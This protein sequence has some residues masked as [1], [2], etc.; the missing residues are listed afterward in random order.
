MQTRNSGIILTLPVPDIPHI[1]IPHIKSCRLC[2]RPFHRPTY[3]S[4]FMAPK[5]HPASTLVSFPAQ[6]PSHFTSYTFNGFQHYWGEVWT[7][8]YGLK[9]LQ[10]LSL[11]VSAAPTPNPMQSQ[12]HLCAP[13][14][15]TIFQI[16][17]KAIF[18]L[19][20]RMVDMLFPFLGIPLPSS[21]LL[22]TFLINTHSVPNYGSTHLF[23]KTCPPSLHIKPPVACSHNIVYL[24]F[25][26]LIIVWN[27]TPVLWLYD[28]YPFPH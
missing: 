6:F 21:C 11:P 5:L 7:P 12:T 26:V 24:V 2:L 27:Q 19:A 28:Q 18:P 4:T 14:A 10:S 16:P 13:G 8:N 23:R 1:H 9:G 20:P 17:K 15:R 25:K 22:H 3:T